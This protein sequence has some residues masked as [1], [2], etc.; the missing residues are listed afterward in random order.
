MGEGGEGKL[1]PMVSLSPFLHTIRPT[2]AFGT[3]VVYKIAG[4][5]SEPREDSAT[6]INSQSMLAALS[7]HCRMLL[8][9]NEPKVITHVCSLW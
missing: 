8:S 1:G 9:Y 5:W 3:T 7:A 4:H 6:A 2:R